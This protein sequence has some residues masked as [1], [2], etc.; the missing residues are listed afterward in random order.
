MEEGACGHRGIDVVSPLRLSLC[1]LAEIKLGLCG[2]GEFNVRDGV[3]MANSD[4]MLS[5]VCATPV[6]Y[7]H[8]TLP[9]I[10]SV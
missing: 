2:H 3:E 5:V 6:S 10:Y 8:L 1:H 7:T 9:T 4:I